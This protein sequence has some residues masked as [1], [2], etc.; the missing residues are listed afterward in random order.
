MMT[1]FLHSDNG[2]IVDYSTDVADYD[3]TYAALTCAA[4]EDYV[5]IGAYYPFN[6][7][8]LKLTTVA[9]SGPT[10]SIEYWSGSNG[11]KTAVE[12]IDETKKLSQSGFL[13]WTPNK[14]Y[15][16]S[17]YD[18]TYIPEL[19]TVTIYD[20]FWMRIKFSAGVTFSVQWL[21]EL[22]SSDDNLSAEYPDLM[23]TQCLTAFKA[24]KTSWEEQHVIAAK[25][26]I[27]DMKLKKIISFK[28][29]ILDRRELT[30]AAT[31]KCAE[32]AY[33]AFGDDFVDQ[34]DS[35]R[36]EYLMRIKKDIFNVDLDQTARPTELTQTMRQG[37]FER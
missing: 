20:L 18:T 1:R 22:F 29:Q 35:A 8:Y 15:G 19:A 5:Y 25:V 24:A 6:S 23:T 11:W 27:D 33:N 16:W 10:M 37:R 14:F 4:A 2:T 12:V 21:G 13:T 3:S 30:L 7:K 31:S 34:R 9:A 36:K 26:V 28:E 17:R 32:I